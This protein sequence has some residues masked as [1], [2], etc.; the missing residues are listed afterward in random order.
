MNDPA[1]VLQATQDSFLGQ[2]IPNRSTLDPDTGNKIKHLRK[3]FSN[4]GSRQ[5]DKSPFIINEVL[6]AIQILQQDQSSGYDSPIAEAYYHLPALLLCLLAQRPWDIITDPPATGLG[7]P[8]LPP[9]RKGGL[10]QPGQLAPHSVRSQGGED[11]LDH[12][13]LHQVRPQTDPHI[14]ASLCGAFPGQLPHEAIFLQDAVADMDPVD[15]I[16]ASLDVE[17]VFLNTPWLLLEAVW[18]RLGLPFYNLTSE[19]IY[20]RRKAVCTGAGFG[21]FFVPG[22]GAPQGRAERSFLYLLVRL[23]LALAIESEY[24][25]CAPYP[26]L[27]PLV[28]LVDDTN[29]MVAHAVHEPH[30]ADNHTIVTQQANELLGVAIPYLSRNNLL[31]HHITSVALIKGADTAPAPGS[32]SCP[33]NALEAGTQSGVIHSANADNKTPPPKLQ[34]H[35]ANIPRYAT[36]ATKAL[37]LSPQS[38]AYYRTGVLNAFTGFQALHPTSYHCPQTSHT[39]RR[40]GTGSTRGLAHLHI[41]LSDPC[42]VAPV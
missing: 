16:I 28:A 34:S 35:M 14:P 5:L 25:V 2:H 1:T 29:L 17:E 36:S 33:M 41:H 38:L 22:S 30:T 15:L 39:R 32:Q 12:I 18:K 11:C 4:A 6:S 40:E 19:Y 13:L 27:S 8:C 9:L 42:F 3:E 7:Q 23:L 31:S 26:I 20:T 21:S 10:G 24:P 37:R